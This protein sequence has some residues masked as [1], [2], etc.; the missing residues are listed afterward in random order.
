MAWPGKPTVKQ[1]TSASIRSRKALKPMPKST[2]ENPN[3]VPSEVMRTL[4]NEGLSRDPAAFNRRLQELL[5]AYKTNG[6]IK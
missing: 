3:G 6:G 1:K 5:S 4:A 2:F